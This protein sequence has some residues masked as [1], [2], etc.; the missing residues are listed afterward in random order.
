MAQ[1]Y[2]GR[3]KKTMADTQFYQY[4]DG[5]KAELCKACLTAHINN[6]DPETFKWLLEKFDVPYIESKWNT[7]RDRAYNK[8]PIKFGPMSVFGKYLSSMKLKPWNQY[9]WADTEKLAEEAEAN[10]IN[11]AGPN[12]KKTEELAA[13]KL[14]YENGEITE[15]QWK[16][17]EEMNQPEQEFEFDPVSKTVVPKGQAGSTSNGF[18]PTN[19]HPFEEVEMPN[20]SDELTAEDK[21]KLAIKWGQLYSAAD[22]VYLEKKW[23]DFNKSFDIQD[24]AR[25]DTLIQICK[26]SLKLNN[27]LDSGDVDTYSKIARNYDALMKSAKFTEAQK[28]E[29]KS[30]EFSGYGQIVAFCEKESGFIPRLE[31]KT[32]RDIADKDLQDM[33]NWTRE[34]IDKDPA[35]YKMIEQYIKKREIAKEQEKDQML[36]EENGDETYIL[37]DEDMAEYSESLA[38]QQEIDSSLGYEEEEDDE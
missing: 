26:L 35:I 12:Q 27:A 31:T 6:W 36:A 38:S 22:W 1:L 18:Y 23:N 25:E 33:K 32:V 9:T 11:F 34:L 28:K 4:K 21:L 19:A 2:C 3:C 29:D 17:Y 24:A 30:Q 10:A 15:A 8:D 13:M 7:L 16:T 5:T 20:F 37:T 14:A